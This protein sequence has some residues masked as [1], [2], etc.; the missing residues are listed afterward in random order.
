MFHVASCKLLLCVVQMVACGHIVVTGFNIQHVNTTVTILK[1]ITKT[2][3]LIPY[4]Q[5]Y[6]RSYYY[7][8]LILEQNTGKN[9]PMYELILDPCVMSPPAVHTD[10]YSNT[11]TY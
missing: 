9:N 8:Q 2:S 3:L 5:L 7:R 11:A 6:I 10:Q 1:Q 4:E